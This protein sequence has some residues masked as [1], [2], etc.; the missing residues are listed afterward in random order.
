MV[1]AKINEVMVKIFQTPSRFIWTQH[2]RQKMRFYRI[3]ETKVKQVFN[4]PDRV[5]KGIALNTI[6]SMKI[7]GSQKHPYE[8]WIMYQKTKATLLSQKN[9]SSNSK[10][11]IISAWRYPGRSPLGQ[12]IEIPDNVRQDLINL[13]IIKL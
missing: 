10:I 7:S 9:F 13:G 1:F 2:A 11:K 12:K 3:P 6:A 4:H 8:V 5:E